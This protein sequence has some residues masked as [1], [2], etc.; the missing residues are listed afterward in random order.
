MATGSGSRAEARQ[1]EPLHSAAAVRPG[2]TVRRLAVQDRSR[3]TVALILQV[4]GRAFDESSIEATTVEDIARSAG[5]SIG[6]VYRYF[7]NKK[8]IIDAVA[9]EWRSRSDSVFAELFTDESLARSADEFVGDFLQR[10]QN[11]LAQI[12]GGRAILAA[13]LSSPVSASEDD[14][15]TKYL[16]R[17]V[18]RHVPDISQDRCTAVAQVFKIVSA[19]LMGSLARSGHQ[20]DNQL[21]EARTLLVGYI[22]EVSRTTATSTS[23]D[24]ESHLS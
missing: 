20:F 5:L 17:Y 16:E 3:A 7:Q 15:W 1:S 2:Q 11:L 10:F 22:Q 21:R 24:K 6:A 9:R 18:R 8:E 14:I 19:T 13:S 23:A 12:P 4:A